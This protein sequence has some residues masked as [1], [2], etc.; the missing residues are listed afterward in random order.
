MTRQLV[1]RPLTLLAFLVSAFPIGRQAQAQTPADHIAAAN[2]AYEA[3][4]APEALK[5]YEAALAIEPQNHEALWR[6]ARTEVEL[7]EFAP[8]AQQKALYQSA[9]Q[10]ARLAVQTD[11]T[12]AWAHFVLA[13]ALGRT[14]LSLG[15]RD[16]IKYAK[17]I[18]NQT[19]ECLQLDPNHPGCLHVLG[20]WNAEIM[21]LNGFQR[22]FAQHFLGGNVFGEASWANARKYLEAA[23]KND[24]RR[25]IHRL[26]LGKIYADMGLKPQA[27]SQ[28]TIAIN[29]QL[30]D[31]NDPHYKEEA[32]Q[33]LDQ[34]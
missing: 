20:M 18:R 8:K 19:L 10:H 2:R 11:S 22:M 12:D 4:N 26:D 32:Q 34:L 24:P 33:A 17:E 27:K 16:R 3:R 28:L 21:R 29:G 13:E 5:E 25:I 30:I 6:I 14:A 9:E 1:T 7:G 31:Y 15:V 23:V